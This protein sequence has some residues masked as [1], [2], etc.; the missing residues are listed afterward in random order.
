VRLAKQGRSIDDVVRLMRQ[1]E[2][3][4]AYTYRAI[5]QE[6]PPKAQVVQPPHQ[7]AFKD[8]SDGELRAVM[9]RDL[10]QQPLTFGEAARLYSV[11][12]LQDKPSRIQFDR[13]YRQF[14]LAWEP[15]VLNTLVRKEVRAWYIELAQTPGHANKALTFLRSLYNWALNM[16]LVTTANPAV[17]IKRFSSGQRERFLSME[18]LQRMMAGLPHLPS[19]PRAYLLVLLFTGAR[20]AEACRMRW[21]DLDETTRL[22]KK[23]RTKNGTSHH[24]PLPVQAMEAIQ[25]LP[26]TNEWVFPGQH[27]KPWSLASAG[28]TWEI[29]RRRWGFDDVCLHDLRR[30][31]ASQLAITGENL[32]TIQNVLNHRSLAPTSIYA[33]INTKAVDRALQDQAD[34]LCGLVPHSTA[35]VLEAPASLSRS[36]EGR[37]VHIIEP[38][39]VLLESP[40]F[41]D[42]LHGKPA[43]PVDTA[44]E[45]HADLSQ[46]LEVPS[47][48][49][50]DAEGQD[51]ATEWPG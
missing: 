38:A 15:R 37:P 8:L 30:T 11:H 22:W 40:D 42:V 3:R 51:G 26:R 23:V 4:H 17:G 2:N 44:I 34:R 50:D 35:E 27:G 5:A 28:K 45:S 47:M 19:K 9:L 10:T 41:V 12:H 21:S 36:P 32:P 13:I 24:V 33:R 1:G 20:R 29:I 25:R 7:P 43:G 18:E 49:G 48:E 6:R 14:W 46:I 39:P 31:C 16:E